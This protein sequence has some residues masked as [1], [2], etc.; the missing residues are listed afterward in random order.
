MV[1]EHTSILQFAPLGLDARA[2]YTARLELLNFILEGEPIYQPPTD[3]ATLPEYVD[4]SEFTDE[5]RDVIKS[6]RQRL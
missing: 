2:F 4:D 6:L 5:E 3:N 1:R